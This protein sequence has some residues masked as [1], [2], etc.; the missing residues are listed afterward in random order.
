MYMHVH[1]KCTCESVTVGS[2]GS[3][4]VTLIHGVLKI[5]NLYYFHSP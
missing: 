5:R 1:V 4:F 3:R 2:I